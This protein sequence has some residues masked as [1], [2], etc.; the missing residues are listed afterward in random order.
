M[1]ASVATDRSKVRRRGVM[2]SYIFSNQGWGSFVGAIVVMIVLLCYRH[3]METK[4]ETSKV[5]G[6]AQVALKCDSA[7]LTL[8]FNP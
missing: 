1:S 8:L 2:L 7:R 6:G 5:D 3:V 4:G